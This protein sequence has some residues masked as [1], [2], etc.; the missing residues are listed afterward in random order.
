MRP[1]LLQTCLQRRLRVVPRAA[2]APLWRPLVLCWPRGRRRTQ[3]GIARPASRALHQ[4]HNL[5][6]HFHFP[7]S[8][9]E[10][11]RQRTPANQRSTG[12]PLAARAAGMHTRRSEFARPH[13]TRILESHLQREWTRFATLRTERVQSTTQADTAPHRKHRSVLDSAAAAAPVIAVPHRDA[14]TA[15]TRTRSQSRPLLPSPGTRA[16]ASAQAA[17]AGPSTTSPP[18]PLVWRIEPSHAAL[19]AA[20]WPGGASAGTMAPAA[21]PAIA[22]AA[23][24]TAYAT[25]HLPAHQTRE[26]V[27]A[28]LMD[29]AIADRLA[30]DVIR[31]V[32]KRLRIERERRGL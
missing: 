15:T 28:N 4:L 31:R 19:A 7:P 6:L 16:P 22:R 21:A 25:A 29:P 17:F 23:P 10:D 11:T 32:E 8:A 26:A 30:E 2:P 1:R 14:L 3:P 12:K 13:S 9:V 24:A 18:A 27:R 20:E 5:A